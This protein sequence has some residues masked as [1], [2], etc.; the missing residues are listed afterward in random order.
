MPQRPQLVFWLA[1]MQRLHA[2][3]ARRHAN[4]LKKLF[5]S[6]NATSNGSGEPDD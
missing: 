3:L 4:E 5:D 2:L 6:M 1:S